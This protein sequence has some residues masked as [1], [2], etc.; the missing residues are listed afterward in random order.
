MW[1]KMYSHP[2]LAI[3]TDNMWHLFGWGQSL[4]VRLTVVNVSTGTAA[5]GGGGADG[6]VGDG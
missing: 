3:E 2:L 4:T 6:D 1:Y 5:G